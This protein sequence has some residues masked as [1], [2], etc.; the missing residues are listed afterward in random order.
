M[1]RLMIEGSI[2]YLRDIEGLEQIEQVDYIENANLTAEKLKDTDAI[3]VR[4]ITKCNES[5]L[6]GTKV[7]FIATATAGFDHIDQD[8]CEAHQIEWQSAKGCNAIAVAQYV[9]AS[10]SYLAL[11]DKWSFKDKTIAIIGVGAVGKE[12]EKIALAL[13]MKVLRYDPPRAEEEGDDAFVSLEQIQE[14]ADIITL[15]VPLTKEGKYPTYQMIDWDFLD[16]C[17]RQPILINACRGDVTPS[18]DLFMAKTQGAISRLVVDCWENE[19][20]IDELLLNETDLAS[21][22]IA[23]FSAEGK[24]RG[25]R[26][27]LDA[28]CKRW[29]IEIK[30]LMK[31][32]VL[33]KP[34]QELI[35]SQGDDDEFIAHCFLHTLDPTITDK[36]LRSKPKD[37]EKLRKSYVY[38]REMSA[39]SVQTDKPELKKKLSGIGFQLS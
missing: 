24:F 34:K 28:I 18:D 36:A 22:H 3:I 39:Y 9:F 37:F 25:G 19:P 16:A 30:D 17:E 13:D 21:P 32:T 33:P 26:M 14:E 27:C 1:A 7:K 20:E 4:S 12:V 5:L 15:H 10:L 11:K 38:P 35:E 6:S 29:G 2:P 8:Y 31:P 23:G